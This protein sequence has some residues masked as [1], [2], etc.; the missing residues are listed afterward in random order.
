MNESNTLESFDYELNCDNTP[1]RWDNW[2]K[3]FENYLITIDLEPIP[4]AENQ[5]LTE[6]QEKHQ[7]KV[8]AKLLHNIG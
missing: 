2:L 3:R 1:H 6:T 8:K 5:T 7:R 4:P